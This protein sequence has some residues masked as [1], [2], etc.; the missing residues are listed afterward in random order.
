M[1]VMAQRSDSA[2]RPALAPGRGGLHALRR[3]RRGVAALE[4]VFTA[5]PLLIIVFGFVAMSTVFYTWS[6][7]Q[8]YA[9]YAARMMSTGQI[10]NMSN[11]A[12]TTSNTT[13]TVRCSESLTP[14]QVEYYACHGL[15]SWGTFS[16]TVSENCAV[17]RVT[18]RLSAS[19]SSAAIADVFT[20]FARR[21]L[22]ARAV[23]MKEGQCP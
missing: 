14:S 23:L 12:I 20:I 2:S 6:T 21:T 22:T 19:A 4:F 7:M 18:V 13:A 3:C 16:V 1:T 5:T 8:S 9:Q 15:P 17:P 10:K 11:G